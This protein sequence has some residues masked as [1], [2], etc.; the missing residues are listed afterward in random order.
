MATDKV[1]EG[2][3]E[4]NENAIDWTEEFDVYSTGK[5]TECPC[6]QGTGIKH[7]VAIFDCVSC[8]RMLVDMEHNERE[9]QAKKKV[10]RLEKRAEVEAEG[11]TQTTLGDW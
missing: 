1:L 7:G 10:R 9:K 3:L 8:D 5:T 6:G 11:Q 2:F 4:D